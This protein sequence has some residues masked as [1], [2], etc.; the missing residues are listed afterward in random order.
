MPHEVRRVRFTSYQ[1]LQ[2]RPGRPTGAVAQQLV[3]QEATRV[4]INTAGDK[5]KRQIY[6]IKSEKNHTRARHY[7]ATVVPVQGVGVEVAVPY[8]RGVQFGE[9]IRVVAAYRVQQSYSIY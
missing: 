4:P 5:Q 8:V 2:Q 3:P 9:Q 7:T 6:T 1:L